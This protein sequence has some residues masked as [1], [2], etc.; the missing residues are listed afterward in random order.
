VKC[1]LVE[2]HKF[3]YT[4]SAVYTSVNYSSSVA[5]WN[6]CTFSC[7]SG[8][9]QKCLVQQFIKLSIKQCLLLVSQQQVLF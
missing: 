8:I 4:H 5:K 1:K 9:N 3:A 2:K 6:N 7:G